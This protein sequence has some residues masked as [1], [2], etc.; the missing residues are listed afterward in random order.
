MLKCEKERIEHTPPNL[1][2][3]LRFRLVEAIDFGGAALK[4]IRA[5]DRAHADRRPLVDRL[6]VALHL[7][8]EAERQLQL[9]AEW[10]G[11]YLPLFAALEVL[12]L[13]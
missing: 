5:N 3:R 10:L 12:S 4:S 6:L 13:A 7:A 11:S 2:A 9:R 8:D 1:C